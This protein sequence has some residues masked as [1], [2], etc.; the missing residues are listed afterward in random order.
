MRRSLAADAPPNF[1][2]TATCRHRFRLGYDETKIGQVL[3]EGAE[4]GRSDQ[5]AEEPP[6][7]FQGVFATKG[8]EMFW[9]WARWSRWGRVRA[10]L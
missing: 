9:T 3:P 1:R 10:P 7:Q 6:I 5:L 4:S 8:P 2:A